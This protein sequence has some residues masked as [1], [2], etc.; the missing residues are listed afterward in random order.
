VKYLLDTDTCIYAI[1]GRISRFE[2]YEPLDCGISIIVLGELLDGAHKSAKI[3]HNLKEVATFTAMIEV[4]ELSGKCANTY[5]EIRT[6]LEKRGETIGGND[7][8]I[9]AHAKTIGCTLVTNDQLEFKR[10]PG[11]KLANWLDEN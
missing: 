1:K 10:V 9:A 7:L 2:R 8:W 3:Q 11:L 6:V 5:G 4:L